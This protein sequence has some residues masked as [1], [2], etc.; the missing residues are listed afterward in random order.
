MGIHPQIRNQYAREADRFDR[1]DNTKVPKIGG[2]FGKKKLIKYGNS[3]K[4]FI[5]TVKYKK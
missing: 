3:E 5:L 1:H 4:N 2:Y